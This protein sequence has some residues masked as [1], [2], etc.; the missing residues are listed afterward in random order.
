M[1][2]YEEHVN[3]LVNLSLA[4]DDARSAH[5]RLDALA[6]HSV[7]LETERMAIDRCLDAVQ[8]VMDRL[9]HELSATEEGP[10]GE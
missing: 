7:L 2:K 4:R 5:Q 8:G 1:P 9:Q 6:G 10:G 3:R